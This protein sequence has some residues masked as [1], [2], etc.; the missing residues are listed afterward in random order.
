MEINLETSLGRKLPLG[1]HKDIL[2][3]VKAGKDNHIKDSLLAFILC[4]LVI[5]NLLILEARRKS[6]VLPYEIQQQYKMLPVHGW[7]QSSVR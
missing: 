5:L 6:N 4:A 1:P 3:L 7:H 2:K